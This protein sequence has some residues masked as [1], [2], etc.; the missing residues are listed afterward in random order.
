MKIVAD[1]KIPF[2]KGALEPYAEMIYLPGKQI[3]REILKDADALLIRTRTKCNEKLLEGTRIKFIGTATIGFDHIDTQYCHKS[4]IIW[5]N[6]P[7][8]NSSSVQQYIAA[9][10]LKVASDNNFS[11]KDK[12]LG[13]IGVGNVGSKVEKFARTIGMNVL[14][15][16]PPRARLEGKNNFHTLNTVL[17]ES[18][19]VTLHVPLNVA[20]EDFTFHLFD[21]I[22]FTGMKKGSWIFNTSRGEVVDSVALKSVLNS[23]KLS[24]AILDVWENEPAI[25][26]DIMNKV[27]IAT[28]HIA[29]YSTDGKANGTALVVNSL[30]KYF[31]LP[32]TNW[33]PEKI[34]PPVAPCILIDCIGKSEEKI[35]NEAVMHTY[36]IDEDDAR[37]RHSPSDFEKLRGNYPL[38]REFTSYT[39]DLKGAAKEV[40]HILKKTGFKIKG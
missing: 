40:K 27:F 6:A 16:D 31:N 5:T 34:P 35:L 39:V 13:I 33:Y 18:D 29:G 23:G 3:E 1:D 4:K 22:K 26:P 7:G 21:E 25:D 9:A 14:L 20:G 36:S 28:P 38:R 8:C 15:N 11:L 32:I 37:L 10:L 17:S 2:L 24:G 12:T 19:I 30:S